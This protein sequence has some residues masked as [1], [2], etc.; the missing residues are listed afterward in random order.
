MAVL[1]QVYDDSGRVAH[2]VPLCG[3]GGVKED[4]DFFHNFVAF[5]VLNVSL[6]TSK[7]V[8]W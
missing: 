6:A 5:L 7:L 2:V 8:A 4:M 1:S 3:A